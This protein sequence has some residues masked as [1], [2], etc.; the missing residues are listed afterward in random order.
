MFPLWIFCLSYQNFNYKKI[1]NAFIVLIGSAMLWYIPTIFLSGGYT[2]YSLFTKQTWIASFQQ[3]SI[4]FGAN[5]QSQL[6]MD[7]NLLTWTLVGIG[8]LSVFILLIFT[9]LNLKRVL[10]LS[11]L[12]DSKTVFLILWIIP[13]F[14]FYLLIFIPKPGYTLVY[15]PAF[16]VIIGYALVKISSKLNI[17]IR[18]V[19]TNYLIILILAFC[20][21]FSTTQFISSNANGIDYGNIQSKDLNTQN[22][23]VSLTEFNSNNTLI[24]FTN[25]DNWR[26]YMYYYY[27]YESLAYV[28][29]NESGNQSSTLD[30]YKNHEN[31]FNYPQNQQIILNSSTNYII[32]MVTDNS[33]FFLNDDSNYLQELQSEINV[34]TIRFSNGY[35]IYYSEISNN[36]NITIDNLTS[37]KIDK[38][39]GYLIKAIN[40]TLALENYKKIV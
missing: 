14:L 9:S 12:K 17:K 24:F 35:N 13:S 25:G 31:D 30:H 22:F 36:T 40:I 6:I 37:S 15:L 32:W 23:I 29:Y 2:T 16:A 38:K 4:F 5:L 18:K 19:Q 27:D 21:I 11:N 26:K 10:R 20:I 8:I 7:Y 3:T 39:R 34:K 1:F 28:K 33:N